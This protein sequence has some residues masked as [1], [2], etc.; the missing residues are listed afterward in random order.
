MQN[1]D[2]DYEAAGLTAN[3]DKAIDP[4]YSKSNTAHRQPHFQ[5]NPFFPASAV[6]NFAPKNYPYARAPVHDVA[7][8]S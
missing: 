3:A 2:Q 5:N 7:Q 8:V 4:E 6:H 1:P